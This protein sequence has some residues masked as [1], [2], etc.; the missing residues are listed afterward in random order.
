MSNTLKPCPFCGGKVHFRN[1]STLFGNGL[2]GFEF[3]IQCRACNIRLPKQYCLKVKLDGD[4]NLEFNV[5][6][7]DRAI[8]DWNKRSREMHDTDW[9]QE[10]E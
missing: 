10:H 1:T 5:D 7:R 9:R 6:E 2:Y 8:A 3:T 4:G